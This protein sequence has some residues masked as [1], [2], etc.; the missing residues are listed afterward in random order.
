LARSAG[1]TGEPRI[2]FAFIGRGEPFAR[3]LICLKVPETNQPRVTSVA[4]GSMRSRLFTLLLFSTAAALAQTPATV[5]PISPGTVCSNLAYC[6]Y[7]N[8]VAAQNDLALEPFAWFGNAGYWV[9][10]DLQASPGQNPAESA[11]YCPGDVGALVK[12]ADGSA[13]YTLSCTNGYRLLPT[14]Y[15][16]TAGFDLSVT[17]NAVSFQR[18]ECGGGRVRSCAWHTYFATTGGQITVTK[19]SV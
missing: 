19:S 3:G 13:V 6:Y 8:L 1:F 16:D 10:L 15:N 2:A 11:I 17:I 18:Y 7:H 5:Y 9:Q 4:G 12:N 14:G